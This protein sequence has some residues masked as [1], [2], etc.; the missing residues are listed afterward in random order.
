MT[1]SVASLQA[2]RWLLR[3]SPLARRAL[4]LYTLA[5]VLATL[6]PLAGWR[7][8][9]AGSLDFLFAPLPRWWTW[10]DVIANVLFYLPFGWLAVLSLWPRLR[11]S[12]APLLASAAGLLLSLLLEAAQGWLPS[13]IPSNLDWAT[14]GAGAVLGAALAHRQAPVLLGEGRLLRWWMSWFRPDA[15]AGLLLL[16]LWLFALLRPQPLPLA[17]GEFVTPLR[18]VLRDPD[19]MRTL[20]AWLGGATDWLQGPDAALAAGESVLLEA[21]VLAGALCAAGAVLCEA[22][23][24]Q[25]PRAALMSLLVASALAVKSFSTMVMPLPHAALGWLSAGVQ[26]GLVLAA[27]GLYVIAS[28]PPA[29]R[30]RIGI[31]LMALLLVLV[32]TAPGNAYQAQTHAGWETGRWTDFSGLAGWT[33]LAWPWLAM[34]WLWMRGHRQRRARRPRE[35][36]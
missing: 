3:S 14:N 17:M 5:L 30:R 34:T 11:G 8:S 33:A 15:A 36:A 16:A 19:W 29:F 26:G 32:N 27:L 1:D 13:R 31:V 20:D 9:G 18:E 12:G 2:R 24:A 28:V 21:V 22:L 7:A 35:P 10:F 23:R 6:H 4:A 25:A